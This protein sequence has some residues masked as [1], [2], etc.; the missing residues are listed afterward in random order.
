MRW[1]C[2]F[3]SWRP[4]VPNEFDSAFAV[5]ARER[6]EALLVALDPVFGF[7]RARLSD[8]AIK[9]RLPAVYGSREYP[10][11]GGL[12]SYGADF[13]HNF[14]RSATYVDKILKRAEARRSAHRATGQI[15]AGDQSQYTALGVGP[16]IS[17]S[18]RLRA[19]QAIE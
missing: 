14:R 5:M 16:T 10:E 18:L 19:D 1:E 7:H 8:L 15:R 11:A 2:S 4:E 3:S 6:A 17:P 9:S 13:R 12:M